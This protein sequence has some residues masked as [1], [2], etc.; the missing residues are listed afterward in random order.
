MAVSTLPVSKLTR[1]V[2]RLGSTAARLKLKGIGGGSHKRW[3]MWF[4]STTSEEPYQ[5]LTSAE[6]P[7]NRGVPAR[8]RQD[9]C[10]TVVVSSCREVFPSVGK[11]AQPSSC[12]R[13]FTGDCGGN[14][15][16]GGDD[17][18]SAWLLRPGRHTCYNAADKGFA[19]PRGGANPRK[20]R[21]VR[22]A[23]CNPPA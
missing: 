20:R 4:N 6:S 11:R 19:K 9:R 2:G 22:I 14:A 21:S 5:G 23:G 16:E 1:E 7:G 18:R 17:V 8:E 10:C 15:E 3:S 13:L 12:V